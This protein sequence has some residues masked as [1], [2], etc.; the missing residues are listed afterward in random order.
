MYSS[1]TTAKWHSF[2]IRR[3]LGIG[4]TD[5]HCSSKL[6]QCTENESTLTNLAMMTGESSAILYRPAEGEDVQVDVENIDTLDPSTNAH[7]TASQ[8]NEIT[9][10]T[11]GT[12][13][14]EAVD[15][16]KTTDVR[17][18]FSSGE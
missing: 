2:S 7:D 13:V 5:D 8:L 3:V 1:E 16:D 9:C 12:A 14:C 10:C 4:G 11:S 17:N 6:F 15:F 18:R